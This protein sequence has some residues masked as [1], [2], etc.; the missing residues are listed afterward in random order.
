MAAPTTLLTGKTAIVTGGT[1]GIGAGISRELINRGANVA[2][3]Y[4][5]PARKAASD[6]FA[7]EL[8]NLDGNNSAI[9]I[10]ADLA[11]ADGP[12]TVV[13]QTLEKFGGNKIDI[14]GKYLLHRKLEVAPVHHSHT[15]Q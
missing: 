1:R 7:T 4:V 5:N 3:I 9:A 2:M 13:K 11:E 10:C 8:S 14:I 15:H 12:A 6:K